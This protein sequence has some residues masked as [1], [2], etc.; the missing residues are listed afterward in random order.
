[1]PHNNFIMNKTILSII[2][3]NLNIK[4]TQVSNTIKLFDEGGTVPFI[5]RYRKEQTG[6]LDE[7]Q[8]QQ[9]KEQNE[10]FIELKKR[11]E[12]VLK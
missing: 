11:K 8:I 2:S 1:M 5:S 9:I 10:K 4:E 12:T 3:H 6:S 7:V